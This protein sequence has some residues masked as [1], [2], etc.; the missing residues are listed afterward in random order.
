MRFS[1]GTGSVA[2]H[3]LK[4]TFRR[5]GTEVEIAAV[6]NRSEQRHDINYSRTLFGLCGLGGYGMYSVLVMPFF[7]ETAKTD[8]SQTLSR[9]IRVCAPYYEKRRTPKSPPLF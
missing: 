1:V 9:K 5:D 6:T 3:N 8:S 7:I 2:T 4:N